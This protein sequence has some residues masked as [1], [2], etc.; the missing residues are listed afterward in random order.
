[1]DPSL[2]Y[3]AFGHTYD[4]EDL[5]KDSKVRRTKST[6]RL[7]KRK[8]I[9]LRRSSTV[10][11]GKHTKLPSIMQDQTVKERA[12]TPK[13]PSPSSVSSKTSGE[14]THTDERRNTVDSLEFNR[15]PVLVLPDIHKPH[16]KSAAA[17]A[18]ISQEPTEQQTA[19]AEE[20]AAEAEKEAPQKATMAETA[21][22]PAEPP[23]LKKEEGFKLNF[24]FD[25]SK[26][27]FKKKAEEKE[28]K[29]QEDEAKLLKAVKEAEAKEAAI[30]AAKKLAAIRDANK[31]AADKDGKEAETSDEEWSSDFSDDEQEEEA[32]NGER[33]ENKA[34]D[35]EA[36]IEDAHASV[37]GESVEEEHTSAVSE[38]VEDEHTSAVSETVKKESA[39]KAAEE[40][41]ATHDA[42][43]EEE[44]EDS[45]YSDA[46]DSYESDF[47][48]ES[49]DE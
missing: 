5:K 49:D 29:K 19:G 46:F 1:M 17:A 10:L 4:D 13:V 22:A 25:F 11:D 32:D 33:N 30:K 43:V 36:A 47:E 26:V 24:K 2:T 7:R 34:L 35:K 38:V 6:I 18:S 8:K 14:T 45:G 48:S 39:I 21:S 16:A 27:N 37:I 40:A 20:V 9:P 41:T 3:N 15:E 23:A 28:K 44:D 12:I 31:T 42:I